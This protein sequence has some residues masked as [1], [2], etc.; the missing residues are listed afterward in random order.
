M[1]RE[2]ND[3]RNRSVTSGLPREHVTPLLHKSARYLVPALLSGRPVVVSTATLALQA[4]LL[5]VDLPHAIDALTPLLGRRPTA[6]VLKGR[7]NYA[8]LLRM[9]T[10]GAEDEGVLDLELPSSKLGEE[11]VRLREW[12]EHTDVGDRDDV[13][14]AVSDRAWRQLSVSAYECIGASR[15]PHGVAC[16][17]E[18]AREVAR[19]ADIVVTNHA[20]LALDCLTEA[21]ILPDHDVVVVDEAHELVDRFTDA[22]RET[23]TRTALE[24]ALRRSAPLVDKATAAELTEASADFAHAIDA[25]PVGRLVVLPDGVRGAL[26]R[27]RAAAAAV[28]SEIRSDADDPVPLQVRRAVEAV[29]ATALRMLA[30]DAAD[31]VSI[32]EDYRGSRWIEVA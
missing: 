27:L 25:A 28:V 8:C 24:I 10:G 11:V 19:G 26:A 2:P 22:A 3:R 14:P 31:V 12:A 23:L 7:R 6:A 15:C 32:A 4:Q 5:D 20:L 21:E 1:P 17:A 9:A 16:F 13:T 18:R 30:N 29:V